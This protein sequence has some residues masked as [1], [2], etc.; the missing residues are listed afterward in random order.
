[1]KGILFTFIVLIFSCH[2]TIAQDSPDTTLTTIYQVTVNNRLTTVESNGGMTYAFYYRDLKHISEIRSIEFKKPKDV[3]RFFELCYAALDEDKT[4][5]TQYYNVSRN[6]ISK[7]VV[8]INDKNE[9]Y[10]LL[11]EKDLRL[12]ENAFDALITNK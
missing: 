3:S 10:F 11:T 6:R 7:Y 4:T 8:R 1:M 2:C 9:G 12:M 5:I